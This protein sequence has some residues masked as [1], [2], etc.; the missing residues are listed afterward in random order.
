MKLT[1]VLMI[2]TIGAIY[3]TPLLTL[4]NSVSS[5]HTSADEIAKEKLNNIYEEARQNIEKQGEAMRMPG[6]VLLHSVD[7]TCVFNHYKNHGLISKIPN[8][9]ASELTHTD[10]VILIGFAKAC[11]SKT[12]YFIEFIFEAFMSTHFLLEVFVNEPEFKEV[13]DM[14]ICANDYAVR[15]NYLDPKVY[16]INHTL[17]SGAEENCK[18]MI[19]KVEQGIEYAQSEYRRFMSAECVNEI[20]DDAKNMLLKY[21]LLVQIELTG[22]QKKDLRDKFVKEVRENDEKL[23]VC[24]EQSLKVEYN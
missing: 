3:C 20:F 15:N 13:S 14:F 22:E 8:L 7:R 11:S 19:E 18:M 12:E 24:T 21:A 4:H 5:S 16:K 2:S 10:L 9:R 17:P 23:V 6:L 1:L